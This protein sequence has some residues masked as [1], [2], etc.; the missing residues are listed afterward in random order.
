FSMALSMSSM[1]MGGPSYPAHPNT[2][3]GRVSGNGETDFR[4]TPSG[5]SSTTSL[6]PAFQCRL[7]RVALGKITWPL[8]VMVVVIFGSV[9]MTRL[10]CK[11]RVRLYHLRC[12]R[13]GPVISERQAHARLP[14][15][16]AAAGIVI[17]H[18]TDTDIGERQ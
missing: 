2:S 5:D 7:L 18:V 6:V 3:S 11:T 16:D 10:Q 13:N 9:P 12:T 4:I 1:E 15:V 14:A 17:G 8:V